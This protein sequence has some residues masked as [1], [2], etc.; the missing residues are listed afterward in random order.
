MHKI[1]NKKSLLRY[2]CQLH[3]G[4]PQF[5]HQLVSHQWVFVSKDFVRVYPATGEVQLDLL[6]FGKEVTVGRK[7]RAQQCAYICENPILI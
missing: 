7:Q 1:L 4:V 5:H 6:S 3:Q 2:Q